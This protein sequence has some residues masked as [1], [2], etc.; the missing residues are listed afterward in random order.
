MQQNKQNISTIK[1]KNANQSE[2]VRSADNVSRLNSR[3]TNDEL[4]MAVEAVR[5]YGK[6]FQ[7]IFC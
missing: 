1:R 7:V 3:W 2:D 4:L 6:D 5:K